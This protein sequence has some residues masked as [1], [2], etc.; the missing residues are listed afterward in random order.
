M[1]DFKP[2]VL[3]SSP[4]TVSQPLGSTITLDCSYTTNDPVTKI[5]WT[6]QDNAGF[7]SLRYVD[8]LSDPSKYGGASASSPSLSIFN[9][10]ETD[11]GAY[12]CEGHTDYSYVPGLGPLISVSLFPGKVYY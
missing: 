7:Y 8:V 10:G 5:K 9:I 11:V 2:P 12:R 4:T 6:F 3:Q 1:I